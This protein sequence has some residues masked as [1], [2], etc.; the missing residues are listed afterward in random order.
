VSYGS[1]PIPAPVLRAC[2]ATLKADFLGLYGMTETSGILTALPKEAH[3]DTANEHRLLSVGRPMPG[4]ELI[5]VDPATG[6]PVPM[7]DSGEVWVRGEQVMS[8]YFG[9]PEQTAD[10]LRADGW[11]RTGDAGRLDGEGYLYLT[12]RVKDMII[13]G[14]ENIYPAE[15]ERVLVEHPAVAEVAVIGVPHPKWGET[16]KAVVV[17][18]AGHPVDGPGLIEYC[19][20]RLARFKCPTSVEQVDALPRNPTGKVLK[21]ELRRVFAG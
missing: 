20:E 1:S 14:G 15:I 11:F 16:P 4:V 9:R 13:S 12:D 7:G 3:R 21:T 18:A 2:L 19:R 17:A 10:A 6:D 8:G 5:V